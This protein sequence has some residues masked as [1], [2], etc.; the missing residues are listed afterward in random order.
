MIEE[1]EEDD[2]VVER[3]KRG[4]YEVVKSEHR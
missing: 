2:E 3:R 1:E 4:R